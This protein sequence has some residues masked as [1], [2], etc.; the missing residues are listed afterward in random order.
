M[1]EGEEGSERRAAFRALAR[2]RDLVRL[3][4]AFAGSML[5]GWAWSVALAV[6]AYDAGGAGLVG[7][8]AAARYG[9]MAV[10]ALFAGAAVARW[11]RKRVMV[12]SDVSRCVLLV[13]SGAAIAVAAPPAVVLVL[14]VLASLATSVFRP[15]QAALLPSLAKTPDELTA[16]NAVSGVV[17][18]VGMFAGPALGGV[19]LVLSSPEVVFGLS[20]LTL[21]WSAA[22]VSSIRVADEPVAEHERLSPLADALAGLRLVATDR[23]ARVLAGLLTGQTLVAGALTVLIAVIALDLLRRG[24]GWVGYLNGAVGVGGVVGAV[25]GA[26]LVGR[27][28][29]SGGFAGGMLLWGLPF[30]LL[31]A[32]R[33]PASAVAVMLLIGVGNS[34]VDLAGY[35]LLQRAVP[36]SQLARLFGA[37]EALMIASMALGAALISVLVDRAGATAALVAAGLLLP[38]LTLALWPRLRAIDA[39]APVPADALRVLGANPMLAVLPPG[40]LEGL[41]LAAVRTEH[42]AGATVFSQGDSGDSFYVVESGRV[43]VEVDGE[44]VRTQEAGSGFGEIALLRDTPRTATVTALEP[45]VLW[46]LDRGPFLAAVTGYLPASEHADGV[47][48]ARLG[49]AA[50]RMA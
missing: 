44:L 20:A 3:Q 11:S 50:P 30:L 33:S 16:A 42:A 14:V 18:N 38:L 10:G 13:L 46:G 6:W 36:A 31:V 7:L 22:L 24:D 15:A 8:A 21:V 29:L 40:T 28:R 23:T 48:A 25:A 5:G 45:V 32:W 19:V 34:L 47:V 27:P 39:A 2:S 41:A 37:L 17:E 26:G 49:H 1:S 12:G 9:T 35:T 43:G 4:L